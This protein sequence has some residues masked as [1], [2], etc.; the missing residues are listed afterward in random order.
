[1]SVTVANAPKFALP[2]NELDRW[3]KVPVSVIVDLDVSIRQIDPAIKLLQKSGIPSSNTQP[4][5]FGRAITAYCEPPDF[6]AVLH[7]MDHVNKGDVLVIAANGS[8]SHAMIG[9]ILGG[10]L[11]AKG[12]AGVVCDGAVRDTANMSGWSDFPVYSA[13]INARGPVGAELGTVNDSVLIAGCEVKPGELIVGDMDGL[14]VLS[15]AELHTWIE[16]AEARL[17][18]EAEWARRLASGES[19]SAVF[20]LPGS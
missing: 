12:V 5:L 15:E 11:S 1:M 6:G 13:S 3:R 20:E 10:C 14:A 2:S 9:D 17:E 4:I 19:V 7:A 16:A 18:Q 8:S